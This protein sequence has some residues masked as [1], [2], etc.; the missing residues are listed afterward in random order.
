MSTTTT[1][2]QLPINHGL[3]L[4]HPEVAI[5]FQ[6]SMRIAPEELQQLLAL[7]QDT[8]SADLRAILRHAVSH[9][10]HYEV[11]LKA[12]EWSWDLMSAPLHAI[13]LL[14]ELPGK[15]NLDALLQF[16]ASE[17]KVLQVHLGDLLTETMWEPVAKL[18]VGHFDRI[19]TFVRTPCPNVFARVM[20]AEAMCRV[21][22]TWPEHKSTVAQW[23]KE[24]L[25]HFAA[26]AEDD[27]AQD[28]T[29]VAALV[30]DCLDH[31]FIELLPEIE[32]VFDKDLVDPGYCGD[33]AKVLQDMLHP[34][35]KPVRET[36]LSL[37]DRYADLVGVE[38]DSRLRMIEQKA[39]KAKQ[40]KAQASQ[41]LHTGGVNAARAHVTTPKVGRNEPCPCGSG[42]KYK[43]CC[44]G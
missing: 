17:D 21:V 12:D 10:E 29:L 16:F 20:A 40:V 23:Y 41:S 14:S 35:Y 39:Y 19:A 1:S 43:K 11:V 33:K 37:A 4:F 9:V 5:L 44:G 42:K 38:E 8:L 3:H 25:T 26:L 18:A 31:Q 34:R 2:A 22:W 32:A 6:R 28:P 13:L 15:E 30:A 24:Q 36:V 27:P 7:P